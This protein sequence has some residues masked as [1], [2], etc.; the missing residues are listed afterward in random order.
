M[1]KFNLAKRSINDYFSTLSP[2]L[3]L[4]V[5]KPFAKDK[6]EIFDS[7]RG[8]EYLT[9]V[10]K[11]KFKSAETHITYIS[12]S[13]DN[14][15]CR[16]GL[17][18][19]L[20]YYYENKLLDINNLTI[21]FVGQKSFDS[22]VEDY[23][24]VGHFDNERIHFYVDTK[25]NVLEIFDNDMYKDDKSIPYIILPDIDDSDSI[26]N[27]LGSCVTN[28]DDNVPSSPYCSTD[29]IIEKF[30]FI[31]T[32][33]ENGEIDCFRFDLRTNDLN[34][35]EYFTV[36]DKYSNCE[37]I[38]CP[39]D[40][41]TASDSE[42]S[43]R[44]LKTL[45]HNILIKIPVYNKD[46]TLIDKL[47]VFKF[48][49]AITIK[50]YDEVDEKQ[51]DYKSFVVY[52]D[53]NGQPSEWYRKWHK[54]SFVPNILGKRM[55]VLEASKEGYL[56][57]YKYEWIYD[58]EVFKNDWLFVAKSVDGES[59][60]ICWNDPD[61]L[62]DWCKNKILIGFNNSSYDD[63]VIRYAMS[64]PYLADGAM[65]VK[66]FSDAIIGKTKPNVVEF[67][68]KSSAA[69]SSSIRKF[70]SWD[71]GYHLEF[72]TVKN[73]LK[74]LTM[75]V[76]NRK[77]Y[78]SSVPFDID[79]TLTRLERKD[80]EKYCELDV[81]NTRDLFLPEPG[82]EEKL[83]ENPKYK[84]REYAQQSYDVKWNLIVEFNM[85]AKTLVNTSASFA[86]KV[87]CGE[88]AVPN[89]NNTKKFDPIVGKEVYY[90]IPKLA[91]DELEGTEI[92]DFYKKHQNNP[93]YIKEKIQ[94]YMG[95]EDDSHKYAFGFGGL[96]QALLKY[97]STNLVNMD[98]A[99][100]YPSLLIVYNLMSR[101]ASNP[102]SYKQI[103][104]TRIKA[105]H[106]GNKLLNLG[107]KLVL[108]A[109]IGAMLTAYNPLYD[110][111]TN[112]T[113]CVHGQL[114]LYILAKRLYDAGFN[115]VQTNTDGIMIERKDDVDYMEIAQRWMDETGLVL[116]FDEIAILAQQNVN[117]YYCQFSNGKVKSKGYY[118]SNE[119]FG[120]ATSKILCNMATDRPYFEGIA[121]RDFVI[122]KKHAKS[123][124]C[125]GETKEKLEGRSLAF[126]IGF[127]E[128][129]RTKE[130]VSIS[131]DLKDVRVKD[132]KGK[133]VLDEF[134]KPV[135]IKAKR[136]GKISGFSKHM[137]LVDDMDSLKDEEI[138]KTA[139]V[140]LAKNLLKAEE[141]FGPYYEEGF[142]KV[143]EIAF[144]QALNP[145]K[146]ASDEH[147]TVTGVVCQNFLFECDYLSKSEQ[148]EIIDRIKPYT[149]RVTWSGNRSY[150]IVI[151]ISSPVPS[152]VYKKLW[153]HLGYKLKLLY[154][155]DEQ[156]NLPNKYTRVP[157]QIN[158]KTGE[159]QT[160][161]SKEGY[162]FDTKELLD[163][164]P[165]N[166]K[167]V[168][169]TV[170]KFT[171]TPTIDAL[172][173]HINRFKWDDGERFANCQKISPVLISLVSLEELLTM[174]PCKLDR[175][176]I[177]VLRG[178]YY[179]FEK[180]KDQLLDESGF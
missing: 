57:E 160:L 10:F 37:L 113:I 157:G 35:I 70:L 163:E 80:V 69:I 20:H 96:H 63:Q 19:V 56:D 120:I 162:V 95:G 30:K 101:G 68:D 140:G 87:L 134:G 137:L 124:I 123:E 175:D 90:S 38:Y 133:D 128:D 172:K 42:E 55:K 43:K 51:T 97:N 66:E 99:S 3:L 41:I 139:Y 40:E 83:K 4:V 100:L 169:P 109:S 103:Y 173:K 84:A 36:Y 159:E 17:F 52:G 147:P 53:K 6:R 155:A 22:M 119:K 118:L 61:T 179:H 65:T 102:D 141:E 7:N 150:H 71:I 127:A 60:V 158:P 33:Y 165:K 32:L 44:E 21:G 48:F 39:R 149:Y 135:I 58:I 74:K 46:D 151:R 85:L 144:L 47:K 129:K 82:L 2:K 79:R 11:S 132:E 131:K 89:K 77:N 171:G 91:Y 152:G 105:K 166:L 115:I 16:K 54:N 94:I 114:L 138:N 26:L 125:D 78:D 24:A 108:N 86:G 170:R 117:N 81:D 88:D 34:R 93:E 112:S 13:L 146:D 5:D 9:E 98:V 116:E 29:K 62:R 45:M 136:E 31:D 27:T 145:L 168:R 107:L 177:N 148:E 176:H 154:D 75:S 1:R 122:F 49:N 164:L 167:D 126:V 28:E 50:N 174:I 15:F 64:L 156:A 161:H 67:K 180:Y 104:D 178:K 76:L 130:Y 92:L 111:W 25:K 142:E 8:M 143:D 153:Y 106:D 14:D 110:T 72:T 121:P 12:D 18:S 73:S 23:H 59:K